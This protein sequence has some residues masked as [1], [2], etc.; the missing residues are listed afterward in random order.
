[1][2]RRILILPTQQ[3][4]QLLKIR[5]AIKMAAILQLIAQTTKRAIPLQA[6]KLQATQPQAIL[7]SQAIP[8]LIRTQLSQLMVQIQLILLLKQVK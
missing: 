2:A 5:R 8:P 3:M 6:T 4:F 1:M 7:R